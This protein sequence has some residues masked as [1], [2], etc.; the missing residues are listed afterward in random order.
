MTS[1]KPAEQPHDD[2]KKE[3]DKEPASN[4]VKREEEELV[5]WP[6]TH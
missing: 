5:L 3:I 4:G 1:P 2:K 6:F